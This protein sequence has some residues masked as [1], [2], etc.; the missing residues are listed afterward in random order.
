MALISVI[1]KDPMIKGH[2]MLEGFS[3][4]SSNMHAMLRK[5]PGISGEKNRAP[6]LIEP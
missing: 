1:R 5:G 3:T 6:A 2:T 4:G